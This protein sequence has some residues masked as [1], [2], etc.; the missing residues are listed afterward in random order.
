MTQITFTCHNR[1]RLNA[2]LK[3]KKKDIKTPM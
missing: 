1:H 2:E 3:F